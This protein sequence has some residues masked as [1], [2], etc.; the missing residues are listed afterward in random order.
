MRSQPEIDARIRDYY[1]LG[2]EGARLRTRSLGGRVEYER[3]RLLVEARLA[4][5]SVTWVVPPVC[6]PPGSQRPVIG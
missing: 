5:N 1:D 4:P 6:T 3:M 2:R